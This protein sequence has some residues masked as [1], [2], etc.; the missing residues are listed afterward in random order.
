MRTVIAVALLAVCAVANPSGNYC[1]A[2]PEYSI[3]TKMSFT[4]ASF[5]L[6]IDGNGSKTVCDN[7]AYNMDGN[8]VAMPNVNNADDCVG[9]LQ[10]DGGVTIKIS[11]DAGANSLSLDAGV[12]VMALASC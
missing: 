2:V 5:N 8:T 7:E 12:G 11:Y 4:E 3:T 6:E 10:R 1:G 9:K